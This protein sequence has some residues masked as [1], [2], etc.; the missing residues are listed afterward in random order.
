VNMVPAAR[1]AQLAE[2]LLEIFSEAGVHGPA[3]YKGVMEGA[4]SIWEVLRTLRNSEDFANPV[5]QARYV[6]SAGIHDLSAKIVAVWDRYPHVRD[7]LVP[8]LNLLARSYH[9]GQNSRNECWEDVD[10]TLRNFGDADKVIELY[11][12]CLCI[13]IEASVTLD[14]PDHSSKGK[15]PD[16]LA[17]MEDAV[18]SIE[19]GS[20]TAS[21]QRLL[22]QSR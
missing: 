16:V 6:A 10:G 18:A 5:V 1:V 4:L 8:H 11:W 7:Q 2:R 21:L 19:R 3:P 13:L 17:K 14:D 9:V 20:P 15:N 12:A 22:N